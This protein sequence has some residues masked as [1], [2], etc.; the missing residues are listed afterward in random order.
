VLTGAFDQLRELSLGNTGISWKEACQ[1]GQSLPKL[2]SLSLTGNKLTELNGDAI[3]SQQ[4]FPLLEQL[5]LDDNQLSDWQQLEV[6]K[7]LPKYVTVH[8]Y[9]F[10]SKLTR[11]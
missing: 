10:A 1:L 7:L 4:S 9:Q 5:A 6:L 8:V 2:T 3:L 11:D